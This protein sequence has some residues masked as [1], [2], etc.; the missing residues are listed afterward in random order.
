MEYGIYMYMYKCIYIYYKYQHI[1]Y[2]IYVAC[3]PVN[4]VS[5][6]RAHD[7]AADEWHQ[8]DTQ[9]SRACGRVLSAEIESSEFIHICVPERGAAVVEWFEAETADGMVNAN[10]QTAKHGKER[11]R[12]R[13]NWVGFGGVSVRMRS[14]VKYKARMGICLVS[15]YCMDATERRVSHKAYI[16]VM[17]TCMT[18]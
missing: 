17:Q 16:N 4:T 7:A 8:P 14:S 3:I 13:W 5:S 10:V 12:E 11:E 15:L 9:H 18:L 1:V 2:N 6:A